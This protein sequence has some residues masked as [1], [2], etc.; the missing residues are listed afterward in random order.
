MK[1]RAKITNCMEWVKKNYD[2]TTIELIT[3]AHDDFIEVSSEAEAKF[4]EEINRTT[5]ELNALA[6]VVYR[7]YAKGGNT[8]NFASLWMA[9]DLDGDLWL[10]EDEP[11]RGNVTFLNVY[12]KKEAYFLGSKIFPQITWEN[13]PKKIAVYF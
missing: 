7:R 2:L 1:Y 9:R 11:E 8:S 6:T 3:D 5:E 13:S 10:Y 12:A 4:L